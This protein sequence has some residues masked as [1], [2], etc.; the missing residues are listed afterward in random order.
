MTIFMLLEILG[1]SYIGLK[2]LKNKIKTS[3]NLKK[4]F[5]NKYYQPILCLELTKKLIIFC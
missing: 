4:Y 5:E 1:D 3:K 2:I